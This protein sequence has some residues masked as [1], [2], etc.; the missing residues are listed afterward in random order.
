MTGRRTPEPDETTAWLVGEGDQLVN[1]AT[2]VSVHRN[3]VARTVRIVLS[4]LE[5]IE[6]PGDRLIRVA[7]RAR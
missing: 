7:R 3:A 2:V 5:V 1:G 6:V 4:P